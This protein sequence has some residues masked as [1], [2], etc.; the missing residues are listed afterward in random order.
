MA[1][2]EGACKPELLVALLQIYNPE[3]VSVWALDASAL[4]STFLR[5]VPLTGNVLP[6]QIGKL[7]IFWFPAL[8]QNQ[9]AVL[10]HCKHQEAAHIGRSGG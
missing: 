6:A 7:F 4:A 1:R 3:N 8:T 2:A 10:R 5:F 9:G